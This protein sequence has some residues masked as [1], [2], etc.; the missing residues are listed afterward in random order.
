M[1]RSKRNA[2][3][4]QATAPS[5][6]ARAAP[7]WID[8]KHGPVYV[9]EGNCYL[10]ALANKAYAYDPTG[11]KLQLVAGSL[12]MRTP[13][14]EFGIFGS[15]AAQTLPDY[16]DPKD[17]TPEQ[18]RAMAQEPDESIDAHV[19]LESPSG[20]VYD[21]VTPVVAA[22]GKMRCRVFGFGPMEAV[23]GV[24]KAALKRRGLI[25]RPAPKPALEQLLA[26]FKERFGEACEERM[27]ELWLE[28]MCLNRGSQ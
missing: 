17:L 21:V 8:G 16:L 28:S 5:L 14:G 11:L 25:Y 9:R 19:W 2:K 3:P 22:L 12:G 6:P 26:L 13:A 4:R 15:M 23:E 27:G 10:Q 7:T 18:Q 24:S 1:A 20:D